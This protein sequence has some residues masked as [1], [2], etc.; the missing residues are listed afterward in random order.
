MKILDFVLCD[1]IR[2]EEG[3]KS[4][5]MG[6]YGD[7]ITLTLPPGAMPTQGRQIG[8]RLGI[9]VRVALEDEDSLPDR[10]NIQ[11]LNGTD[12]VAKFEGQI[13]I[14]ERPRILTF[15][16]MANPLPIPGQCQL[17]FKATFSSGD[18]TIL[19]HALPYPVTISVVEAKPD[20]ST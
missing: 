17:T 5:L 8:L 11:I 6:V 10:F 14:K 18:A 20:A 12:E 19:E 3:K 15:P 7:G 2:R 16:L 4:S 9:F 1:D 13:G